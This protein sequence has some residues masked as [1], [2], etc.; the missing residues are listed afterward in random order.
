[1]AAAAR[2]SRR[3][4]RERIGTPHVAPDDVALA[5]LCADEFGAN[6]LSQARDQYLDSIALVREILAIDM[7]GQFALADDPPLLMYQI[8]ETAIFELCQPERA[9][10]ARRVLLLGVEKNAID[11]EDGG[12]IAP[13]TA[14]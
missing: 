14:E 4:R 13:K 3:I 1:M 5:A 11:T 10:V 6:L 7:L 2:A 12:G 9:A 8:A